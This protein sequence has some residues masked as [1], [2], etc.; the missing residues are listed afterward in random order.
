[1][2]RIFIKDFL[3]GVFLSLRLDLIINLIVDNEKIRSIIG[4]ICRFYLGLYFIPFFFAYLLNYYFNLDF[5]WCYPYVNIFTTVISMIPNMVFV[6][7]L[8]KTIKVKSLNKNTQQLPDL[9]TVGLIMNFYQMIMFQSTYLLQYLFHDKLYYLTVIVIFLIL[10]LYHSFF[11]YNSVWRKIN[12]KICHQIDIHQKCWG[13]FIGYGIAPSILYF[14]TDHPVVF[15]FYNLYLIILIVNP[16][17][18][19]LPY[20]PKTESYPSI[21]LKIFSSLTKLALMITTYIIQIFLQS[22]ST[23]R[24]DTDSP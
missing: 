9:I 12:I 13:Y 11:C 20:P 1:M 10:S 24:Y 7:D 21:N 23:N 8:T 5:R 16:F 22:K 3:N 14:F 4:K 18:V 17:L 2:S 19:P 6:I 15:G